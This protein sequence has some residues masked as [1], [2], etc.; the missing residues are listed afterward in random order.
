MLLLNM[1]F[2]SEFHIFYCI[3]RGFTNGSLIC[4]HSVHSCDFLGKTPNPDAGGERRRSVAN[5]LSADF[6]Q[7]GRI[8]RLRQFF[9][10]RT[11]PPSI[12]KFSIDRS[13]KRL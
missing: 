12:F 1:Y 6:F 10:D 3:K 7:K 5:K 11:Q 4:I 8:I 9:E 2:Q 13:A